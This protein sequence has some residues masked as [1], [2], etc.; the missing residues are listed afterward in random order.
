MP[1]IDFYV[2]SDNAPDAHLR[3]VCRLA[4]K[5]VEQSHKVFVR[6]TDAEDARRIDDL[7]WTDRSFLPHEIVTERSPSH[8]RVN[9]LIG[10]T[11]PPNFRYVVINLGHGAP[12]DLTVLERIA[13]IVPA[14]AE[15]KKAARERFKVYRDQG[16][17]PETHN[18]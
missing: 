2:L 7:L 8:A 12:D 15:R 3:F 10:A 11:A 17:E 16:L 14:D 13:E 18:V 1:K 5:A 4:E 6:A 9:I